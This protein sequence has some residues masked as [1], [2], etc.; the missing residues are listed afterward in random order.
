MIALIVAVGILVLGGLYYLFGSGAGITPATDDPTITRL[1]RELSDVEKTDRE[2][3]PDL[4]KLLEDV[5]FEEL[6]QFG[7]L[8]VD[9]GTLGRANPFQPF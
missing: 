2:L 8:P 1:R 3:L 5:R 4:Q 7:E 6:K 9:V